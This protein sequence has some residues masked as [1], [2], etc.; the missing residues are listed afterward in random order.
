MGIFTMPAE[1]RERKAPEKLVYDAPEPK[2]K[3]P[4]AAK[5]VAGA[6][7]EKKAKKGYKGAMGHTCSSSKRTAL[8]SP[9]TTQMHHSERLASFWVPNGGNAQR[10]TRRSSRLWAPR[11]RSAL[12][13][14]RPLGRR[15]N[16]RLSPYTV[17]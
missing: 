1:K 10:R 15:H 2:A 6:K 9:P 17:E 16:K 4:K 5:K 13:K 12:Q 11:T 7:K 14:T 8:R 3:K